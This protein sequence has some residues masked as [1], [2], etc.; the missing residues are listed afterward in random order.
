MI[1]RSFSKMTSIHA[2][3]AVAV[4]VAQLRPGDPASRPKSP[5]MVVDPAC[6]GGAG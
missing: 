5:M 1:G 4:L 2:K 3:I 6:I